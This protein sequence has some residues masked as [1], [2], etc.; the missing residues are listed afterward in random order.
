VTDQSAFYGR[1]RSGTVTAPALTADHTPVPAPRPA[2]LSRPPWL[3]ACTP[4][5]AHGSDRRGV[6]LVVLV[7]GVNCTQPRARRRSVVYRLARRPRRPR[8]MVGP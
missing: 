4:Y 6:R 1:T 5:V 8:R 3:C 7:H 2:P